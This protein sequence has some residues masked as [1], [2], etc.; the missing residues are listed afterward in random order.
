MQSYSFL[1]SCWRNWPDISCQPQ[2]LDKELS[3]QDSDF[4]ALKGAI[5]GVY[6]KKD[7]AESLK[8]WTLQRIGKIMANL[9][10]P[11]RSKCADT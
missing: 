8:A 6:A 1:P 11:F 2:A 4:A 9:P 5:Q 3:K 10:L 7:D